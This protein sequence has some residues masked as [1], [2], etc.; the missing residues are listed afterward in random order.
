M[1]SCSHKLPHCT[2][3]WDAGNF[4]AKKIAELLKAR[5]I[6]FEF[7]LD[8]GLMVLNGVVPA[9]SAPVAMVGVVEKVWHTAPSHPHISTQQPYKLTNT[10]PHTRT[11]PATPT[12]NH[13]TAQLNMS[14]PYTP[15]DSPA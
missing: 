5:G 8:E 1:S 4:G 13:P 11:S 14:A 7:V 6:K 10:A 15:R 12:R 2:A 3:V 9:H